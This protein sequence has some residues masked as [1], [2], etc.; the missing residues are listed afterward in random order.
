VNKAYLNA[1]EDGP[2]SNGITVEPGRT[3]LAKG[4]GFTFKATDDENGGV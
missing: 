4:G 2:V 3:T 1:S